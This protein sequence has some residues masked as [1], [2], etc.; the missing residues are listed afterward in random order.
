MSSEAC[1]MP[2]E[3]TYT[4]FRENLASI[5]DRVTNDQEVVIVRRRGAEDVA[6]IPASEL[7]SILETSYVLRS[8]KNAQRLL[9]ALRR[10]ERCEGKPQS[11]AKLRHEIGLEPAR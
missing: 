1:T 3:T 4:Q 10:A 11:L 5:L 8:P 9:R 2:V 7:A 6:L